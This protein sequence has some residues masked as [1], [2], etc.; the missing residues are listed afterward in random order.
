MNIV[1]IPA[2]PGAKTVV[3]TKIFVKATEKVSKDAEM[4]AVETKKGTKT[5]KSPYEGI[6]KEILINEGEEAAVNTDA[7]L[8]E[9]AA[10]EISSET[11]VKMP[12]IPGAKMI[13]IGKILVKEGDSVTKGQPLFQAEGKKDAVSVKAPEDGTVSAILIHEGDE[14]PAGTVCVRLFAGLQTASEE[15]VSEEAVEDVLTDVLIIGGGTGGY[16]SAIRA[17][18]AGKKVILAEKNRLGGTCLN[19]GCIPTKTLIASAHR[20]EE[21]LNA[22]I[23]GVQIEGTVRPD[24]EKIIAR[25]DSVVDRLVGGIEYLMEKNHVT[26]MKGTAS[27][28]NEKSVLLKGEKSYRISFIDCIIATGSSVMRPKIEGIEGRRIM[29][30]TV[31]LSNKE[32][33]KT[34]T[35]V[36]GGVIGLEFAF[37]YRSLGVEVTVIE[38]LDRL[39]AVMDSDIS[40]EILRIAR[41]KGIR[42]EL[43]SKVTSFKETVNNSVVTFYEKDGNSLA[44]T[45]DYVLVAIGRKSNTEGLGLENTSIAMNP[46]NR[47]IAVNEYMETNVPHIYAVGDVNNRIQLAHAASYEGMIAVDHILGT[48]RPFDQTIIPSVIFTMPEMASVGLNKAAAEKAG[49]AYHEGIF[50][51]TANGKALS[52]NETEGFIRILADENETIIGA[53]MIGADASTIIASLG[54]CVANKLKVN[55]LEK[56]VFAHPTTAE[57][58]H[59]A[60]LDLTGGAYHE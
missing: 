40:E 30:S 15:K 36:G 3:V 46:G 6:V 48:K 20:Y 27:F 49:I 41:E 42:V 17:A 54:I 10:A 16:V 2:L 50:H 35:I 52:M 18:R 14:V 51:Y 23:F 7:F 13:R 5:I 12:V 58:I 43:S 39:C 1:K 55:D 11:E 32:L 9:E 53:S 8:I 60:A 21:A 22:S 19:V 59:E 57:V 45:S 4:F 26:V 38:F 37:L 44:V 56:T 31:A 25:K 33:M 34:V 29:D 47:G 24:M 28:E